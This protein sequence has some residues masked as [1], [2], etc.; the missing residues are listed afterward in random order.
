MNAI[1]STPGAK[2]WGTTPCRAAGGIQTWLQPVPAADQN[3]PTSTTVNGGGQS[4]A[5]MDLS[6]GLM[7]SACSWDCLWKNS[8]GTKPQGWCLMSDC[9]CALCSPRNEHERELS[10]RVIAERER[11]AVAAWLRNR[12]GVI[13]VESLAAAIE[14]GEHLRGDDE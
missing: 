6:R 11:V 9:P 1:V 3:G 2:H 10:R 7:F 12:R 13:E 5:P 14:R 8:G 4:T